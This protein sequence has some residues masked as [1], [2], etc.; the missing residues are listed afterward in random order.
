GKVVFRNELIEVI[1]YEPSTPDVHEI[2]LLVIPPWINRY[3]IADLAPGK[4]L[5]GWAVSHG[6]TTFTMSFRNADDSMRDLSFDDYLRLAPLTAIDVV[7]EITGRETVNTLSICLGGTMTAMTLAYL[8]ARGDRFVNSAT[9][10]NTAVDYRGAGALALMFS[11][12][13]TVD[14]L[15]RRIEKK[16]YLSGKDMA[17]TF[18]ILRAND[19][20]FRYVV[21]AWLLGEPA[22]AFDLLA[23]N[24]DAT[25]VP[26]RAHAEFLRSMYL[27]HSLPRDEYRALGERLMVSEI[28]TDAYIV[29][30]VE[31]HIVPWRVSYRTTQ[32]FKGPV[33]FTRTSGGHIAG[34]VSPPSP[35]ARLWTNDE[36][37]PDPDAWLAGAQEHR[38]TWW[39]DWA[40]WAAPRAGAR[41]RPP[42][43][44]SAEHP[45]LGDAPGTYVTS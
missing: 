39:D 34:I 25:N 31:D 10:L 18:D 44:G 32:L 27:E 4:S 22:P 41:I 13:P 9:F 2:P 3:Y 37:P 15:V 7:R 29:A 19:L 30:G 8:D 45:V 17:H 14:A 35:R 33:R 43:M 24:A 11:D 38:A 28:G 5:I 6:H 20:V 36:L 1:Q 26:G 42:A 16:G 12:A 40:T 21:D 23:W